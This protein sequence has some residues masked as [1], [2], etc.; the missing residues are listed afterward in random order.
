MVEDEKRI[1]FPDQHY[2]GFRQDTQV[3]TKFLTPE[4]TDSGAKK[5]KESVDRWVEQG[6]TRYDHTLKEYV[7]KETPPSITV[8][9]VPLEG[10]GIE[11]RL[12]RGGSW[13]GNQDKWKVEDPR[14]FQLEISGSNLQKII[15][16]TTIVNGLI[17]GPCIWARLGPENILVPVGTDVYQNAVANTTRAKKS[18]D[19]KSLSVGDYVIMQNGTE[20][21]YLGQYYLISLPYGDTFVKEFLCSP[22]KHYVFMHD[23]QLF[24]VVKPKI[25]E[26]GENSPAMTEQEINEYLLGDR[27][28]SGHQS[29]YSAVSSIPVTTSELMW[30]M[31]QQPVGYGYVFNEHSSG[32]LAGSYWSSFSKGT[33]TDSRLYD[34]SLNMLVERSSHYGSKTYYYGRRAGKKVVAPYLVA[35]F[36]FEAGYGRAFVKV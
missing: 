31:E 8:D 15:E 32:N 10:F 2:V 22:K 12:N 35:A 36:H 14:G 18:T 3:L 21:Q 33:D 20:G 23:S 13:Y 29:S 11:Q 24:S 28:I 16:S 25:S 7:K 27:S 19:I 17:Q 34:R 5:R 6:S 30:S 4:G 26:I 9:N 1:K